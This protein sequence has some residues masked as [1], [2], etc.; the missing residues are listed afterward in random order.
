MLFKRR[1]KPTWRE[2]VRIWLWPRRSWKRSLRYLGKR[3]LRLNATPH[4]IA[5]GVAAGM[6][7]TFTPFVGFHFLIAFAIAYLI[8][9]NMA[10]A[11]IGCGAGNPLTF[12]PI[13]ASTYE[14]GRWM[15]GSGNTTG[16]PAGLAHALTHAELSDIWQPIIKPMLIGSVPLGLGFALVTYGLVYVAA[17]SFQRHRARRIAA[18]RRTTLATPQGAR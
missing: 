15:L 18:S 12:G 7:S 14:M 2:R 16:A 4:A 17:R 5:A 13:W 10:A 9:G 11:A 8:A 3:V 1:V 6:F